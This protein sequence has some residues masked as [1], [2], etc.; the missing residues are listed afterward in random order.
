VTAQ[1][2]ATFTVAYP[3]EKRCVVEVDLSDVHSHFTVNQARKKAD[4]EHRQLHEPP[5]AATP[6]HDGLRASFSSPAAR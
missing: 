5:P 2:E 1:P 4:A 3:C 6:I